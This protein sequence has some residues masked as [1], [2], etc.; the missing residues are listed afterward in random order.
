MVSRYSDV[1]DGIKES[2]A[3]IEGTVA[4]RE[5]MMLPPGAQLE[6]QLE[7]ISKADAMATVLATVIIPA[8][9]GPPYPFAI[10]YDP[11]TIDERLR[12][13]LRATIIAGERMIGW[14]VGLQ[15]RERCRVLESG[16]HIAIE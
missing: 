5:R 10:E 2:M 11:T 3:K 8:E 6:V 14:A 13:A 7:D 12:Y 15:F 16:G 9:G 4:Y 1:K